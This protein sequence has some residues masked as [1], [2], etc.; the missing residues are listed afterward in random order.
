MKNICKFL[1][2]I[3][4]VA[5]IGFVT[6]CG[7]PD[8]DDRIQIN[9]TGLP[10]AS[11][12]F[13]TRLELYEKKEDI[14]VKGALAS[15]SVRKGISANK[16]TSEM[17]QS[18]KNF[19]DTSSWYFVRLEIYENETGAAPDTRYY[20]G[21]TSANKKFAKGQN[22]ITAAEFFPVPKETDFPAKGNQ[23]PQLPPSAPPAT[24][25]GTYSGVSFRNNVTETVVLQP[26]SFVISDNSRTPQDSLTFRIDSWEEISTITDSDAKAGGYTKGYKFKGKIIAATSMNP[27][28]GT[29]P[30]YVPSLQTAPNFNSDDVKADGT[31]PDCWMSIYFKGEIGNITFIRTPFSKTSTTTGV[32][33]NNTTNNGGNGLVRSYTKSN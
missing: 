31:G 21:V 25:Y 15:S 12:G 8:P 23:Q 27:P 26:D 3:A 9:I 22:T 1:G 29:E 7:E 17:V 11:N 13:Y 32:V 5:V 4:A 6:G 28:T 19:D 33:K 30:G 2:I 24:N 16:T 14:G 20:D 18:G 10:E